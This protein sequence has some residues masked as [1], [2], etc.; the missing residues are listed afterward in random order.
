[1]PL[2]EYLKSQSQ[3][4]IV[5]EAGSG[6]S[7]LLRFVALDVLADQPVLEAAKSR[8]AK[9]VPVWLPFALWVRMSVERGGPV[10]VEDAVAEFFRSQGDADL[11]DLMRRAVS[12]REGIVLLVDGLD[13]ASDAT[14]ART[15]VA[16][17]TALASRTGMPILATSRPHGA[18]DLSE[19]AGSWNRCKLAALSDAQ[20]HALASLW[21]G[22]LESF[23]AGATATPSQLRTRAKRRAD[24][25]IKALQLNAGISRLSQTP[26]FLLAFLSL[27]RRGQSLPRNRF[28]AS[29]EIVEQLMEHQPR[30]RDMSALSTRS[31]AGEFRCLRCE[32]EYVWRKAAEILP[33]VGDRNPEIKE[34][35]LRLAREAPSVQTAQAA[36]V[37]LGCGWFEDQGVGAL[38]HVLRGSSQRSLRLDAIRIRA[39]R[40]ETDAADLDSYFA[41]AYGREHFADGLV[42]RDLAEHFAAHHHAAF[43]GKLEAA[44]AAQAAHGGGYRTPRARR[45]SSLGLGI[46]PPA[47]LAIRRNRHPRGWCR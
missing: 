36:I 4:L 42:A 47:S 13:E 15:L 27:H 30:R 34:R 8:F 17:L 28:A 21:F 29:Q 20:R 32:N 22:V 40:G 1:V 6:K 16:V 7:S 24:A 10:P 25:F 19:L 26:L 3:A 43:V 9:A 2:D 38:A 23:E 14:A 45:A 37:S 33:V 46:H 44:I 11:A 5:S 41:V 35:L 18:R 12:G 39:M 31:L